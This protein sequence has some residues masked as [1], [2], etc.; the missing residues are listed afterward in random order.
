MEEDENF[1]IKPG[2]LEMN[3]DPKSKELHLKYVEPVSGR[4][5]VV[6]FDD[7]ATRAI[8]D[9]LLVA[10]EVTGGPLGAEIIAP[11]SRH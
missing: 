9:C 6:Q 4:L 7:Q 10:A 8:Y 11:A 2:S 5:L 1:R 3:Y